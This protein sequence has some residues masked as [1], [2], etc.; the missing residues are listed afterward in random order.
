LADHKTPH[1]PEIPAAA[2]YLVDA[3]IEAGPTTAA[4]MGEIPLTWA[5]LMAYQSGAGQDF[6]PWELRLIRRL[7]CEYLRESIR[8]KAPD[9]RAPWIKEVT[10]EQRSEVAQQMRDA[11]RS[12]R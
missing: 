12:M 2:V 8:A 7:S 11:L 6:A 10:A 4:G 9:A 3:L 5:D 1:Y